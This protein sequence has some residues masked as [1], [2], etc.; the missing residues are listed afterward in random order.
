MQILALKLADYF[1]IYRSV[2]LILAVL[3][4]FQNN[5]A[6]SAQQQMAGRRK[7]VAAVVAVAREYDE[8]AVPARH[9]FGLI[10]SGARRV[11]HQHYGRDF[12][13]SGGYTVR[14]AHIRRHI[15]IF[16]LITP[17]ERPSLRPYRLRAICSEKP[18]LSPR[19]QDVF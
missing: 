7:A 19:L 3:R 8:R 14:L 18:F 4:R 2:V 13:A 10:R 15:E 16:H 9:S 11:L 17:P 12:V 6:A 1:Q 5:Y